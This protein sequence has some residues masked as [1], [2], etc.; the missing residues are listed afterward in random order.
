MTGNTGTS[1]QRIV[2]LTGIVVVLFPFLALVLWS[3]SRGWYYPALFP[4]RFDFSAW[5]QLFTQ[6][7]LLFRATFNSVIIAGVVTLISI[8][9]S[10]PA[11]R[12]IALHY[13]KYGR[14]I[15]G[16]LLF[17]T[18]LPPITFGVGILYVFNMLDLTGTVPGVILAHIVPA[19]SF[20][21]LI[22]TGLFAG[23][24]T[25]QEDAARSLGASPMRVLRHVTIP[26]IRSGIG[27]VAL[28]A[29]LISWSQ[30]ALSLQIGAGRV[31]TLPM[32][33]FAYIT[34][35]NPQFGSAAGL[36][37]VV[38]TMIVL[39]AAY[40]TLGKGLAANW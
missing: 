19:L 34:G 20:S 23:Y 10:L 14:M 8:L 16:L 13:R 40:R 6:G 3:I 28:F 35:G 22:T 26:A 2:T 7:S 37:M 31:E 33:V 15:G 36:V 39:A 24:D 32:V 25:E 38:P 29:F 27:V 12:A 5:D 18:I 21:V 9:V 17:T 11:G 30:Y 4:D 1:T